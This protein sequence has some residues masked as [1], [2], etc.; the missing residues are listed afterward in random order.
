VSDTREPTALHA[1]N[2]VR[3]LRFPNQARFHP[4]KYLAGLAR[5]ITQ[6]GG[7][8]FGDTAVESAMEEKRGRK[9]GQGYRASNRR[10]LRDQF[11]NRW[12]RGHSWRQ[13][14]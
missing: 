9:D 7:R 10:R 6:R 5:A 1:K 2:L 12:Q 13:H 11:S 14:R 8:L 4:L 3:S